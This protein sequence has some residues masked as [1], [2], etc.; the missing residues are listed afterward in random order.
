VQKFDA[1]E[2]AD[3]QSFEM[4]VLRLISERARR[5]GDGE[6][7]PMNMMELR[8]MA[9]AGWICQQQEDVIDDLPEDIKGP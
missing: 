2:C 5:F 1:T 6:I 3:F 8:V 4:A 7:P 9:L